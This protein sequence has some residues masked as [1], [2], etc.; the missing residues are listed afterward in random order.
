[1]PVAGGRPPPGAVHRAARDVTGDLAAEAA[2]RESVQQAVVQLERTAMRMRSLPLPR[3]DSGDPS[4]ATACHE[5]AWAAVT[6]SQS[7]DPEVSAPQGV[8]MPRLASHAVGD[9]L[10]IVGADLALA[11]PG[12]DGHGSSDVRMRADRLA[13]T[14]LA[15]RTR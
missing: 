9:L 3:L 1:M 2:A 12:W 10:A 15:L 4:L 6:L 13:D 14:C 8:P 7:L 5:L 11:L